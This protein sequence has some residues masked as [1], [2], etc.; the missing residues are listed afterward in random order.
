MGKPQATASNELKQDCTQQN[1]FALERLAFFSD[2]VFAIA[3]TIL[4]LDIRLPYGVDSASSREL[5]L[6]LTGLWQEYLAFFI[7]F[8][9]IGL[10]WIS[11]HRK[12]LYIQRID[13]P[14]LILNLLVLMLIAFIPFPTA[15]MS[16]NVNFTAT[17]FYALTMILSS[18]SGLILWWHAARD[19]RLVDPR[20]DRRQIWR[21]ASVPLTTIA[22]FILSIGIA[23]VT[24]GL[25]RICWVLVFP[26][27]FFLRRRAT[28]PFAGGDLAY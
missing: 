5:F 23:V 18:L 11:H 25:A 3:I 22:I 2:A 20:L 1:H 6:L 4:V 7:S 16:E 19:H 27:A 8:W 12:F 13:Y 24:P 15:V 10:S 28:Q 14:L 21:E 17:T 9:V 26:V